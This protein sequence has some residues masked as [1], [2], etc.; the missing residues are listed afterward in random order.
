[1]ILH[2]LQVQQHLE[3]KAQ[4]LSQVRGQMHQQVVM[5]LR[6]HLLDGSQY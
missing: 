2:T 6:M 5:P 3:R 4:D 1:M